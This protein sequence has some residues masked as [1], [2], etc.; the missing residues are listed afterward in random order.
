MENLKL[1][2]H[3]LSSIPPDQQVLLVSGGERLN[4]TDKVYNNKCTAGTDTCPIFLFSKMNV[5][6]T[7]EYNVDGEEYQDRVT[8]CLNMEPNFNTV[9]ART[10]MAGELY[11]EDHKI[12]S[13][14]EKLVHDQHL[15]QQGWAAVL[16]NFEDLISTFRK[17][18][19]A[20]LKL[21]EDILK[22][23]ET[24]FQLIRR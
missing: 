3:E 2:I 8:G 21:C 15:Q 4:S 1:A 7:I 12:Y 20:A 5:G 6:Y 16:A 18:G 19:N 10:E 17:N 14:C 23:K 13:V 22:N 24:Y 9:Q 11:E